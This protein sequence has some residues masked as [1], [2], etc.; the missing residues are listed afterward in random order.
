MIEL[1]DL[2]RADWPILL[3]LNRASVRELSELNERRLRSIV[4]LA[5]RSLVI[6]SG[7]QLVAFAIAIGPGTSYD[8]LNYRW[9]DEHYRRFL[10]LDRIAV[11]ASLRRKGIGT[12]LYD[13]METTAMPFERMVCDVNL[14]PANDASLAFHAA[15][16]YREIG[17]LAH[18]KEKTV[19]LLS[20]ELGSL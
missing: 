4:S 10:Y 8:S 1:R 13:E 9:F 15:R 2:R 11:S 16:G 7:G 14:K 12:R 5:H 6:E 3:A 18:S 20:K 19:S 17:Q